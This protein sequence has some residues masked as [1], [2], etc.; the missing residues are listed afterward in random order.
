M[1]MKL[2]QRIFKR[3]F[4]IFV[5][6]FTS[7]SLV[8]FVFEDR[9]IKTVVIQAN[10]YLKV[11][12]QVQEIDLHFW[13]TFPRISVAFNKVL[14]ADPLQKKDIL[15]QAEQISLRFNPFDVFF[16]AYQIQQIRAFNGLVQI[17]E[18]N[19]G[20]TNFDILKKSNA[21]GAPFNVELESIFLEQLSVEYRTQKTAQFFSVDIHEVHLSG[22]F[23]DQKTKLNALGNIHLTKIKNGRVTLLRNQPL[24]FD[25]SLLV[26]QKKQL[27][28]LPQAQIKI[29]NLPFLIDGEFAPLSNTL[30]IR[31]AN[32][33]LLQLVKT[34]SP[35]QFSQLEQIK[36]KG[37][38]DFHLH[39][40]AIPEEKSPQVDAY[41]SIKNGSLTEPKFGA[42]IKDLD[43]FGTYH[44]LP[45]E[46]LVIERFQFKSQ[47]AQFAGKFQLQ[48]FSHPKLNIAASG[49]LPLALVQAL[50]PLPAIEAINGTAKLRLNGQFSQYSNQ[51]WQTNEMNGSLRLQ[52][53]YIQTAALQKRL[54]AITGD[55]SFQKGDL[56]INQIKAQLGSSSFELRG[57][58][59]AIMASYSKN[60]LLQITGALKGERIDWTDFDMKSSSNKRNWIL[61]SNLELTLPFEINK[62]IYD[63]KE[64]KQVRGS[65]VMQPRQ[66]NLTKLQ[67]EHVQGSWL[68]LV[69]LNEKTPSNFSIFSSGSAKH[70]DLHTFFQQWNNFDQA[71][72]THEHLS[73]KG[74]FEFDLNTNYD[75]YEGLDEASLHAQFHC[76]IDNG[77]LYQAPILNDLA[78]SLTFGKGKAIL[79]AKNQTMLLQRLKDV[80]FQTL[81]NTFTIAERHLRFKKMHIGSSALDLDLV[82]QHSFDHDIDYAIGLRLR[83]LLVQETQTEFGEITDDGTGVRLFVRIS[84]TLDDP[85]FSWDQKGKKEAA[86][87]QF[88]ESQAE[89][90]AMLKA[91]FGIYQNDP[92]VGNYEHKTKPHETIELK[93]KTKDSDPI[94]PTIAAPKSTQNSK[95]QQ[96]LEKW[97]L[98]QQQGA[99]VNVKIGG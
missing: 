97:K 36:A 71:V 63:H 74:H 44:N 93:F 50:Y 91:V 88:E 52:A 59:P 70:V 3:I 48:D 80:R 27:I 38:I 23:S 89:S 87:Q 12:V 79:G 13:R 22:K 16:G 25:L 95:L 5:I 82:G 8:L 64:L 60:G 37:T 35:A 29:A 58:L 72:L 69:K 15:L 4:L 55:I 41:F 66:L 94:T 81:E 2:W 9:I 76:R 92:S 17:K 78:S 43:C 68:G 39:Y 40:H 98:E 84:G 85:K 56:M 67:F 86:K 14:I 49:M 51:D 26:D 34:L 73:G 45:T 46:K 61:P 32:V 54:T 57:Q 33:S 1:F 42:Q 75:F 62:L 47:G 6:F 53:D 20:Q 96:K 90:K 28:K 99:E 11:P 65:L 18:Y 7:I 24:D 30:D 10:A 31:S 21:N 77:R 83:D 19:N